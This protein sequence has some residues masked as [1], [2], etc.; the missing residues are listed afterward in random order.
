MGGHAMAEVAAVSSYR[1]RPSCPGCVYSV[2]WVHKMRASWLLF[3]FD[4]HTFLLLSPSHPG[5]VQDWRSLVFVFYFVRVV[6][7]SFHTFHR[8]KPPYFAVTDQRTYLISTGTYLGKRPA[9]RDTCQLFCFVHRDGNH[10]HSLTRKFLG[11]YKTVTADYAVIRFHP[12][13]ILFPLT[14]ETCEQTERTSV[15]PGPDKN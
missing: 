9:S 15:D 1:V 2:C 10:M 14:H 7:Y 4:Q 3:G 6:P 12:L 8:S 11:V 13:L 5:R